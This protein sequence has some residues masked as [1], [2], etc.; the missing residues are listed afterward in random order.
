MA[1]GRAPVTSVMIPG[2]AE[3]I[4]SIEVMDPVLVSEGFLIDPPECLTLV[5]HGLL[6]VLSNRQ[7][8]QGGGSEIAEFLGYCPP[9][10]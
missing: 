4:W 6:W 2:Y 8:T 9:L 5:L 3:T 10:G 7:A 1:C